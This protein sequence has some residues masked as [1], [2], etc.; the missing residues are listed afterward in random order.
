MAKVINIVTQQ[1]ID[2]VHTPDY[3]GEDWR[4]FEE[5]AD[6]VIDMI[7]QNS[8]QIRKN[9]YAPTM[10]ESFVPLLEVSGLDSITYPSQ[11]N[12][13]VI[14]YIN[15]KYI[16][17]DKTE[18]EMFDL[19]QAKDKKLNQL[20]IRALTILED[21]A[22]AT[23]G[24]SEDRIRSLFARYGDRSGQWAATVA[25]MILS[26]QSCKI[27]DV[28]SQYLSLSAQIESAN[29]KEELDAIIIP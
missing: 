26:K 13:W 4:I 6:Q 3:T 2:S 23:L 11:P 14:E 16:A 1:I 9:V 19:S 27:S 21:R 5:V 25:L 24:P 20:D 12:T 17:R 28:I 18:E 15:G 7:D 8:K 10:D 29:S 22:G